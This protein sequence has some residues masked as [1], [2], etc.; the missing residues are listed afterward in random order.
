M[1]PAPAD[2]AAPADCAANK[3]EPDES[4]AGASSKGERLT[5]AVLS[6]FLNLAV[7]LV[8]AQETVVLFRDSQHPVLVR[9]RPEKRRSIPLQLL[10]N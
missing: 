10:F 4:A 5:A 6:R 3:E 2:S 9:S 8:D 7:V 1:G